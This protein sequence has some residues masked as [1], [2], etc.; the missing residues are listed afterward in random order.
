[1]P[2]AEVPVAKV[3]SKLDCCGHRSTDAHHSCDDLVLGRV[4]ER[5][6]IVR[7]AIPENR[8]VAKVPLD[9]EIVVRNCTTYRLDLAEHGLLVGRFNH[10]QIGRR[11]ERIDHPHGGRQADLKAD[12]RRQ[13]TATARRAE[14]EIRCPRF[15]GVSQFA[16]SQF[17]GVDA[18]RQTEQRKAGRFAH[19]AAWVRPQERTRS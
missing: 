7:L 8:L 3:E 4:D 13:L 15:P 5:K 19:G 14:V 9:A 2:G 18:L 12:M 1:M 11:T 16:E 10:Q 6:H 17:G